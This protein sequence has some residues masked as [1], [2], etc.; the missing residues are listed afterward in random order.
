MPVHR[1]GDGTAGDRAAQIPFPQQLATA[2]VQRKEVS[3]SPSREQQVRCGGEHAALGVV[4]HLEFS[5][6]F[7]GLRIDRPDRAVAFSLRA[8][9]DARAEGAISSTTSTARRRS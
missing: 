8:E 2:R 9:L 1:E 5:L 7:A 4:N 6:L 3:F